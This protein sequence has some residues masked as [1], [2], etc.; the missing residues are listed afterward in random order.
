MH[1]FCEV[2]MKSVGHKFG[3][4][5]LMGKSSGQRQRNANA[6]A[7]GSELISQQKPDV[8]HLG[9]VFTCV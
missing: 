1:A 8:K 5:S 6:V 4:F 3:T 7:K 2:S 9:D